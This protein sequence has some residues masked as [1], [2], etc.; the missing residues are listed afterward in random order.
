MTANDET[1]GGINT[2]GDA[3]L[4]KT[5]FNMQ[6]VFFDRP[7]VGILSVI[8]TKLCLFAKKTEPTMASPREQTNKQNSALCLP[9]HAVGGS[10]NM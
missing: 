4:L 3:L 7:A 2:F 1:L 9:S 6:D 8:G 10:I 5:V